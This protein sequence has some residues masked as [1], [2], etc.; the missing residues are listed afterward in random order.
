MCICTLEI[1]INRKE[2]FLAYTQYFYLKYLNNKNKV[3]KIIN[4]C[5]NLFT[6][7]IFIILS[8]M[9]YMRNEVMKGT[10]ENNAQRFRLKKYIY[11]L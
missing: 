2:F 8:F 9:L 6:I 7:Y 5:T 4:I 11:I 3:R 10:N 1:F